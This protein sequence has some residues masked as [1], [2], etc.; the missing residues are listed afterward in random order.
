[1]T[2]QAQK[3][4]VVAVSVHLAP[5]S[6]AEMHADM[7]GVK[8][9]AT[10]RA[11]QLLAELGATASAAGR[12]ENGVD[13]IG[14]HVTSA[15]LKILQ[16]SNN[17][18]SFSKDMQWHERSMLYRADGSLAAIDALLQQQGYADV[19]VTLNH[20]GM[21]HS[22]RKDGTILFQAPN[23]TSDGV[24]QK[25]TA[26]LA[27]VASIPLDPL[28]PIANF[29]AAAI[30]KTAA[31]LLSKP[32]RTATFD[33]RVTMRLTR[34]GVLALAASDTVRKMAPVGFTD[35][36]RTLLDPD[37]MRDAQ[38]DGTVDVLITVRNP[39][40]GGKHNPD[41]F[42]AMKRSNKRSLD[43]VLADAGIKAKMADISEFGVMAG[44]LTAS[45]LKALYAFKDARL[46]AVE[47]NKPVAQP[48]LATSTAT[49][50]MASAWNANYRAASQY[51]F[52]IDTGVQ[53][54][55]VF[56]KDK[57]GNSR[58]VFEACFGSNNKFEVAPDLKLVEYQSVCLEQDANGDSPLGL[59]GSAAPVPNCSTLS[60]NDCAHGTHVAGIAA[61]R[62]NPA[63]PDGFRELQG[64][65]PDAKI[66]A[67]Q[68]A[69][70]DKKRI[71]YPMA[72]AED[73]AKAL[74]VIASNLV[75]TTAPQNNPY[76]VNLSVGRG[77][78]SGTCD[79]HSR[80]FTEA[81]QT[82]RNGGVPV[83]AATGNGD[84]DGKGYM[85]QITFPACVSG[86]IKVGAT[87]NN[88]N[89]DRVASFT[90]LPNLANY[91]AG[92]AVWMVPGGGYYTWVDSS[93]PVAGTSNSVGPMAGTSMAAP[94]VS[95][96]YAVIKDAMR[97]WNVVQQSE[98]IKTYASQPIGSYNAC[99]STPCTPSTYH[100]IRLP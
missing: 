44:R 5:V 60:P 13:R 77:L 75:L 17:A 89:D 87:R 85:G 88:L 93:I 69:S 41:T 32:N 61:G 55:H 56:F 8:R 92:D 36:R 51:I 73:L 34:E 16:G 94:H 6:L 65:A 57:D 48:T 7:D 83:V 27:T 10:Q 31:T 98:W 43:G 91:P 95:G 20:E 63:M 72:Y 25:A 29:A 37:A 33:P 59:R 58:V 2:A 28:P 66:V 12:W 67:I 22:T 35:V 99:A 40:A 79:D 84:K 11:A 3:K 15:G 52:I 100:R 82:L 64:V 90:N 30:P 49:M 9:K 81:V 53:A 70:F 47:R 96:L 21:E 71:N 39:L 62:K 45:E 80:A 19:V 54:D 68:A 18:V 74:Q 76:V 97:T 50:N 4:G 26:L 24:N 78:Y 23:G 14:L 1:M 86:V 46:L 42:A 38:R